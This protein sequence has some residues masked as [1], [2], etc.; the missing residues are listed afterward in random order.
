MRRDLLTTLGILLGTLGGY[1][2]GSGLLQ[3]WLWQVLS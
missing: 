3:A 2:A 1:A